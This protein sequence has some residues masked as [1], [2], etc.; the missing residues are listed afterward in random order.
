MT[1]STVVALAFIELKILGKFKK[2]VG[3]GASGTLVVISFFMLLDDIVELSFE[4]VPRSFV[5][6]PLALLP[7]GH[8]H[9]LL[10]AVDDWGVIEVAFIPKYQCHG[11]YLAP[12]A[13]PPLFLG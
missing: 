4:S 13:A 12:P 8:L 10:P 6:I 3:F 2:V 9:S 7:S 5:A 11:S 1:S